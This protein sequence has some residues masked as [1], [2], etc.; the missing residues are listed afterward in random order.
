MVVSFHE[1][2]TQRFTDDAKVMRSILRMTERRDQ[3]E[4]E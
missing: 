2:K 4:Y 3:N 1:I